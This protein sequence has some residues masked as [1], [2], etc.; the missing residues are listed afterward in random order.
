MPAKNKERTQVV[1]IMIEPTL[2]A[3]LWQEKR[4]RGKPIAW[5]ANRALN[6]YRSRLEYGRNRSAQTE[7][8]GENEP[9]VTE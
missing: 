7:T 9:M 2:L 5:I 4:R 1:S 3:W 6:Q 8:S